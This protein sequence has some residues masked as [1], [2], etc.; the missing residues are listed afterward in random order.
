LLLRAFFSPV[1][2]SSGSVLRLLTRKGRYP[3]Y[4]G[5]LS[6]SLRDGN[7]GGFPVYYAACLKN[8]KMSTSESLR[9]LRIQ[10][11]RLSKALFRGRV[12]I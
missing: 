2:S 1:I 5:V 7:S 6:H 12:N 11:P 10:V 4:F 9:R 8:S 3:R